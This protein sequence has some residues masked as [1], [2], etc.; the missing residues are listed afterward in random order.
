QPMVWPMKVEM[1]APAI[2]TRVV[3]INPRGLFGPGESIRAIRPA[4]KPMMITHMMLDTAISRNELFDTMTLNDRRHA[5]DG[6]AWRRCACLARRSV[7]RPLMW[8]DSRR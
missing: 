8:P 4:M 7:Y 2:P 3:R 6:Q 1:K 5:R